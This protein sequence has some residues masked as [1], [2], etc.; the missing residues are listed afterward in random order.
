MKIR[1]F[2]TLQVQVQDSIDTVVND[3]IDDQIT[4][5]LVAVDEME[6]ESAVGLVSYWD[7]FIG[8]TVDDKELQLRS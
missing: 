2:H 8:P 1:F 5:L 7:L 3:Q 4:V 6:N